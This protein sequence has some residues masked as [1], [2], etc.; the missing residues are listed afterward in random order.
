MIVHSIKNIMNSDYILIMERGKIK[1]YDSP[2]NLLNNNK[3]YFK[4]I[5]KMNNLAMY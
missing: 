4:N 2:H 5:V 3:S 1:E